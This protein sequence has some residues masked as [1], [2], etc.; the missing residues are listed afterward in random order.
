MSLYEFKDGSSIAPVMQ[1][2]GMVLVL[3]GLEW[4]TFCD[5][6]Q[7]NF[8]EEYVLY[9]RSYLDVVASKGETTET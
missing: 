7:S 1:E 5:L 9:L 3:S 2:L 4:V 6:L 8:L